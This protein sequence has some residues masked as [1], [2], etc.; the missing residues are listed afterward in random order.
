MSAEQ[1]AIELHYDQDFGG[2]GSFT[3]I[4]GDVLTTRG[5]PSE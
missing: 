4:C 3:G 2:A 5:A 1:P